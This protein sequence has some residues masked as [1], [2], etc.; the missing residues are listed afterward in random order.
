MRLALRM[1]VGVPR[2]RGIR[3][4]LRHGF[5]AL[6]SGWGVAGRLLSA[7]MGAVQV[8]EETTM[9]SIRECD[10][11]G[12]GRKFQVQTRSGDKLV[13]VVH[14]DGRQV[15]LAPAALHERLSSGRECGY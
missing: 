11:P 3:L 12:I 14:D 9:A 5:R 2:G 7:I 15:D 1:R 8:R 4:Y 13:V 10:L 6:Q